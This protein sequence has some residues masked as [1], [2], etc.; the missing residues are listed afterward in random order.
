M[1]SPEILNKLR[2]RS[3]TFAMLGLSIITEINSVTADTFGYLGPH[4]V[5]R[6][7]IKKEILAQKN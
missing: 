1:L 5:I 3:V 2:L 4:R 6:S 7:S